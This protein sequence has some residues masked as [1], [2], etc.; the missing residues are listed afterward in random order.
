[1]KVPHA[2]NRTPLRGGGTE[3]IQ[4]RLTHKA[5]EQSRMFFAV[6]HTAIRLSTEVLTREETRVD[7]REGE[8][9]EERP[10]VGEFSLP[11]AE[12]PPPVHEEVLGHV[13][14]LDRLLHELVAVVEE[15]PLRVRLLAVVLKTLTYF[16]FYAA[17][18]SWNRL[19]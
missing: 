4:K 7:L 18:V 5:R 13:V 12:E 8:V 16:K 14:E 19:T 9:E 15:A 3:Y 11:L 2:V 1:M 17:Y 10:L 6:C